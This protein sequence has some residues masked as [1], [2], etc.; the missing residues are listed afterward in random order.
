MNAS[1]CT[2]LSELMDHWRKK[3]VVHTSYERA[4]EDVP[5]KIDHKN[6]FFI[7]DGGELL[8]QNIFDDERRSRQKTGSFSF[9]EK[10]TRFQK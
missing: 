1:N 3:P 8:K 10:A 2:S 9:Q 5:L 6:D 4:G 7:P